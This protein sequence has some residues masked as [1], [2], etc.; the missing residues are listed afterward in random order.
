[1]FGIIFTVKPVV[2]LPDWSIFSFEMKYPQV[3]PFLPFL[4][5][6]PFGFRKALF[7]S[8]QRTQLYPFG[9]GGSSVANTICADKNT[10]NKASHI[11]LVECM[12]PSSIEQVIAAT[13]N[14]EK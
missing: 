3:S 5:N 11:N 9:A 6:H 12:N 1:M 14:P 13:L 4:K 7:V 10:K 2:K 8:S